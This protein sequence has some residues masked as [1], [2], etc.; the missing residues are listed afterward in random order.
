MD[1]FN[2]AIFSAFIIIVGL[3]SEQL[4][5][6]QPKASI[7][8]PE[9]SL[10][11]G[12]VPINVPVTAEFTFSN[13]GMIPIIITDV[14]PSCGC[15]VADYP[16]QPIAPGQ[17]GKILVTYDAKLSGFFSKTITVQSNTE[18]ASIELF[19]KGEVMK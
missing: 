14:K 2:L 15:T 3:Q 17:K 5:S 9:T 16:K 7:E 13:P 1:R 19:I 12:K 10:D 18:E 4:L 11:F 6:A 8:W